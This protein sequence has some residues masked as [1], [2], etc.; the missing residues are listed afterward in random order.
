MEPPPAPEPSKGLCLRLFWL[1][2]QTFLWQVFLLDQSFWG[3]PRANAD[4]GIE[5]LPTDVYEKKGCCILEL[6]SGKLHECFARELLGSYWVIVG[7]ELVE[8][9]CGVL[10]WYSYVSHF[11]SHDVVFIHSDVFPGVF[12]IIAHGMNVGKPFEKLRQ[13][14]LKMQITFA[15]CVEISKQTAKQLMQSTLCSFKANCKS[16]FA[17]SI[18][19]TKLLCTLMKTTKEGLKLQRVLCSLLWNFKAN[20]KVNLFPHL[21]GEGC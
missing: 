2:G 18:Q 17:V 16:Y 14:Q 19:T 21:S 10:G 5:K 3:D 9:Y 20:C 12:K 4:L 8:S 13:L 1:F 11:S 6:G 15:V 7:R